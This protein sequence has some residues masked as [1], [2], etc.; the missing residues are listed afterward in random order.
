[1]PCHIYNM[2]DVDD[3]AW[4]CYYLL[5]LMPFFIDAMLLSM[6]L[7]PRATLMFSP[8]RYDAILSVMLMFYDY[9]FIYCFCFYLF[10]HAAWCRWC[11]MMPDAAMPAIVSLCLLS[12]SI[13]P[14]FAMPMPMMFATPLF[15]VIYSFAWLLFCFILPLTFDAM[16]WCLLLFIISFIYSSS[17]IFT[18]F[19]LHFSSFFI[20]DLFYSLFSHYFRLIIFFIITKRCW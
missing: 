5:I 6:P 10:F 1:M 14:P 13:S 18:H 16:R 8:C 11:L 2:P 20:T 15:D 17:S 19:L 3:A 12:L 4:C 7:M 9:Y